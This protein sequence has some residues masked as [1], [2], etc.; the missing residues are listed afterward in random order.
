MEQPHFIIKKKT[1]GI[2][3]GMGP[4]ASAGVYQKLIFI[5]QRKFGASQDYDFPPMFLYSLPLFDWNTTGFLNLESVKKQ[6]I[7]GVRKLEEGGCDFIV[8]ACNTVHHFF[9]EMQNAVN[10]PIINMVEET[11]KKV[12]MHDYKTVAVLGTESSQK[13]KVHQKTLNRCNIQTVALTEIEQRIV[14]TVISHAES[15]TLSYADTKTLKLLI[16]NLVSRGAEAIILACTEL[17]LAIKQKDSPVMLFDT[18]DIIC[19]TAMQRA[20]HPAFAGFVTDTADAVRK[21][22]LPRPQKIFARNFSLKGN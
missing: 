11:M 14:T 18:V 15:G 3:G 5:A 1:I 10:I 2:L 6:L 13:L 9:E 22:W 19:N 4:A 20:F 17:P 8:I 7:A 12:Q 16:E 21:T